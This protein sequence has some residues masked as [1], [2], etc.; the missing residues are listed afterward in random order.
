MLFPSLEARGATRAPPQPLAA[1]LGGEIT[2]DPHVTIG[3]FAGEAAPQQVIAA[4]RTL[5]GSPFDLHAADLFNFSTAPHP[6]FGHSLSLRV[7]RSAQL[8]SWHE[9]TCAALQPIG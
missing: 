7:M 3:Y 6:L 2:P 9:S 4:L 5:A 8:Q 1:L